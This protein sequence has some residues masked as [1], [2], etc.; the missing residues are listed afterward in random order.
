MLSICA[1]QLVNVTG[2]LLLVPLFLSCWS[3]GLYGEWMAL[4]AVVAYFG[5][6][7]L[8]MNAAA[9]NLM[10][11]AYARGD[12]GR[13]RYLQGSAMAFYVSMA[14]VASLLFGV[15]IMVLPI[16]FWIGIRLIPA[17][18]AIWVAWLLAARMLWQMPA[19]QVG[20]IYRTFGNLAA[21]QW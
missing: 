6:T 15:L 17:S 10:T 1:G 18:T 8:G 3:T 9:A 11:A 20:S 12:L 4:S 16:P 2:N 13:Y 21:T 14:L 5:V 7:D 19:A